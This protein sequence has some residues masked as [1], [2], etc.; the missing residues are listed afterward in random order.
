MTTLSFYFGLPDG[1]VYS[2][3][4][5]SAITGG[6]TGALVLWRARVHLRRHAEA[7][8]LAQA[9]HHARTHELLTSLHARLDGVLG[10]GDDL[11]G[12]G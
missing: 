11:D 9:Q 1:A 5:A 10:A 12:E 8:A 2:N 3:L 6:L 7:H 4:I